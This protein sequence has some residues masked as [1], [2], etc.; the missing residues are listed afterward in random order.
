MAIDASEAIRVLG[1][2]GQEHCRNRFEAIVHKLPRAQGHAGTRPK[3]M[4][5]DSWYDR[6]IWV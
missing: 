1:Q 5:V 4:L 3:A 6:L 2:T